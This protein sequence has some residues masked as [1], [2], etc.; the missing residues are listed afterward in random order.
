M[1]GKNFSDSLLPWQPQIQWLSI[2][3]YPDIGR[4]DLVN[5]IMFV[6]HTY[7]LLENSDV[8]FTSSW[9]AT[10]LTVIS[11]IWHR[12]GKV[13]LLSTVKEEFLRNSMLG[14]R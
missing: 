7:Y 9:N 14:L 4:L 1:K 3:Y 12:S 5:Y 10:F 2:C 13:K 8:S 6:K 11:G